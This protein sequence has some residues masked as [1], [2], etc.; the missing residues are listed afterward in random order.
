VKRLIFPTV[1][2]VCA[3]GLA[4]AESASVVDAASA[5]DYQ[6]IQQAIDNLPEGREFVA[7]VKVRGRFEVGAPL[8]LPNYTRLD[9]TEA[10][11]ILA[12]GIT[13]PLIAN[14]DQEN[15]NHHIEVTGGRLQGNTPAP[16]SGDS[17]GISFTRVDDARITGCEI[18][19]FGGD[20]I[21]INGLGKKH[22]NAFLSSLVLEDNGHSGLNIMWASRNVFVS[23]V[24]VRGNKIFGLRSDHSEGSYS[25]IQADANAGVG[26]FIRNIFGGNYINLTATRNGK[27]G[28]LVQ[29]MVASLGANWAAHNNGASSPGE[30]SEIV[31]SADDTL[32]Y[33]LTAQTAITG[34]CAGSFKN[35]GEPSAKHA[36][37]LEDLPSGAAWDSLQLHSIVTMPT[38]DQPFS[39][40]Q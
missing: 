14:A 16:K 39:K 4:G 37:Q 8:R 5:E 33:G 13:E 3:A 2:L 24:L 18:R 7:T 6:A 25:N 17:H 19:K 27:T 10:L 35:Y 29:G 11:L 38:L 31:F 34:I 9:L 28:I 15:G 22:R 21:R 36:I 40:S 20:G 32:S 30:F 26:I 12:P 1:L 23:D